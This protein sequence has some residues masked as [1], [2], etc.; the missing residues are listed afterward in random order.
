MRTYLISMQVVKDY[1]IIDNDV[2][3][4][5]LKASIYDA[6][7]EYLEDIIGTTLY[8]KLLSDTEQGVLH[9]DYQDLIVN[10]IWPY[11]IPCVEFKLTMNLIFKYTNTAMVKNNG[12]ENSTSLS[13]Q[14]LNVRRQNIEQSM[15]VQET[16]LRNYLANNT[17]KFPE[18]LTLDVEG[19]P[20]SGTKQPR[21]FY[22]DDDS[23]AD[24]EAY[25]SLFQ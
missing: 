4:K 8:K 12:N 24:P 6:Q 22:C 1:T 25:K 17:S 20:P 5:I 21:N 15:K 10:H 19:V 23:F 9:T 18:Y 3:D 14:E 16:K 11:L 2:E 13:L 7:E